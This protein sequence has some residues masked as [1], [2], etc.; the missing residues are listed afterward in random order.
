MIDWRK[1][2]KGNTG[3]NEETYNVLMKDYNEPESARICIHYRCWCF[4]TTTNSLCI[5]LRGCLRKRTHMWNI[6]GYKP[7]KSGFLT[8]MFCT[9]LFCSE[10]DLQAEDLCWLW[11][12]HEN[13]STVTAELR[14]TSLNWGQDRIDPQQTALQVACNFV[15]LGRMLTVVREANHFLRPNWRRKR[16]EF[17]IV[18]HLF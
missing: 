10:S 5:C 9:V 6:R 7:S 11:L 4:T 8:I 14:S 18:I 12:L 16:Q 2:G 13:V 1:W 17:C 3:E 15:C